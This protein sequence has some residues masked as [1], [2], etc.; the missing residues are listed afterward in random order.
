MLSSGKIRLK[1]RIARRADEVDSSVSFAISALESNVENGVVARPPPLTSPAKRAHHLQSVRAW[2]LL[3]TCW[4]CPD[5]RWDRQA[6]AQSCLSVP[7]P[8]PP[9]RRVSESQQG[10]RE[11]SVREGWM[12]FLYLS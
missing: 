12:A 5:S 8:T 2:I 7:C 10:L 1:E 6:T 3:L 11:A 9:E 4:D